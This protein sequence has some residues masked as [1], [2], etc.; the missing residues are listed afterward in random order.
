MGAGMWSA[1]LHD[2][3]PTLPALDWQA[4]ATPPAPGEP[5]GRRILHAEPAGEWLLMCWAPGIPTVPHDHGGAEGRI[6]VL[7]G[8]LLEHHLSTSLAVT[9]QRSAGA[10]EVMT[11][12]TDTIH[13]VTAA[14][15]TLSL[16]CYKPLAQ[17]G[18]RAFT[19]QGVVLLPAGH[20][21][22]LPLEA[23]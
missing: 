22:W 14:P 5:Y 3:D 18:M 16:H 15:H 10:G 8:R 20:G 7:Q 12:Q 11:V 9:A 17:R 2:P 19:E 13:R 21:A 1:L 23:P 4:L 6:W